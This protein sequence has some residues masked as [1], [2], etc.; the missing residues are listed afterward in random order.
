MGKRD[1][2]AQ[3]RAERQPCADLGNGYYRN[4]IIAGNYADPSLVRVDADY[5][6]VQS[7]APG[8]LLWHSRDLVNWR[9]LG[10]ALDVELGDIWAP[11]LVRHGELYYLYLPVVQ[12]RGEGQRPRFANYVCTASDPAGPW[13]EPV[14]L[15]VDGYIDPGHVADRD[16]RR[17]LYV[18]AG[19]AAPL[20]ADGLA[21]TGEMER[22]YAGWP[23]P[24][25]WV[26][27]CFCLESPKFVW[28]GDWLY[29]V[30]AQGGTWGPATSHMAVVARA[31]SPLGP[32]ENSPHNPLVHT[33][34]REEKWWSQGHG[35][36]IDDVEGRWW[37][38]YHA[39]ERGYATLGRPVLLLPVE[40]TDDGWPIVRQAADG[41]L[42]KPAGEDVGHGL[43][44]SD[45]F[46][47]SALGVQW[48]RT[49]AGGRAAYRCEDGA[50]LMAA[51]GAAASGAGLADWDRVA[52]VAS[53]PVNHS[54]EVVVEIDV[55]A[56]AEAGLLLQDGR[57]GAA[58]G[59]GTGGGRTWAFVDGRPASQAECGS[60]VWLKLWHLEHDVVAFW[61]AD[62]VAWAKFSRSGR[63]ETGRPLWI[64]L[65]A[66]GE[67]VVRFRGLRYLGLD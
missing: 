14:D 62:G 51:P 59:A 15:H 4:P 56:G 10:N 22:V 27:E 3:V 67:G 25:E 38:V 31:R 7:M 36:L 8:V 47:A 34:S 41:L 32:W 5:Y 29:L 26:A 19:M 60:R 52:Y 28:R 45:D 63:A 40:W 33:G 35:T 48:R 37:L 17:Y 13:S 18:S 21:V 44:L 2:V 50:L 58:I 53:S 23:Y 61:S 46:A 65:Y 64:T 30:S 57:G 66:S 55:P 11:E 24:D 39:V 43:P 49:G 42:P 1:R 12:P 16:G 9:P 20:S 54:Y 6:M